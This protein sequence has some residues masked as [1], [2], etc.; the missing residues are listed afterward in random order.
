MSHAS[1]RGPAKGLPLWRYLQPLVDFYNL[2]LDNSESDK[3]KIQGFLRRHTPD[4][5][6]PK[7][8]WYRSVGFKNFT[9][10]WR[11]IK[12]LVDAYIAGRVQGLHLAK[13]EHYLKQH[14][15]LLLLKHRESGSLQGFKEDPFQ[16]I[17]FTQWELVWG[18]G[19]VDT[20]ESAAPYQLDIGPL[21]AKLVFGVYRVYKHHM[22]V[23]RCQRRG[24]KNIYIPKPGAPT[25]GKAPKYCPSCRSKRKT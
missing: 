10:L 13:L 17:D 6:W 4:P 5:R 2:H 8:E 7:P 16:A 14:R 18:E 11:D 12:A 25:T 9:I 23:I 1:K 20:S 24:C 15:P 19:I 3:E 22:R 21:I